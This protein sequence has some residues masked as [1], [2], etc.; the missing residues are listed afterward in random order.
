MPPLE[1]WEKVFAD[2]AE[3]AQSVHGK[4]G[5]VICHG[6]DPSAEEMSEEGMQAAH[7]GLVADPSEENC[8]TCHSEIAEKNEN[9]LHTTL[10]GFISALEARGGNLEEGSPLALAFENHC[11]QCHVS[12]GQCHVSRPDEVGGGFISGHEFRETPNMK[13]NC[14]ACHGS[15]VGDE[16]L[17]ENEGIPRD[18]HRKK[19]M[20]CASCHGQELHGSGELAEDRYHTVTAASCDDAGCHEDVWTN[21]EGNPQHEQ[22]LGDLACQVCHSLEYKNCYSCHVSIDEQGVPCRTSEPSVMGFE[23]GLNPLRSSERPYKYVVLRHVPTCS[24]ECGYYGENLLPNFDAVPTWKYATPHNIQLNTP[25]NASC[26]SCHGNA[27]LFLTEEDLRPG[28]IEANRDV[29][30]PEIPDP[31]Y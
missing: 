19:G 21:T 3:F 1:A 7:Q 28:E 16:F 9:S 6:G 11:Q 18:I 4:V 14:V 30:V 5:C 2:D 27:D 23:I 26:D 20:Q 24:D 15:R 13:N 22:H 8:N 25:Q 29:I 31:C 12:C 17:G 10:S